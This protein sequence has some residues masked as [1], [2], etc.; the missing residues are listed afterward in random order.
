M[1]A[2]GEMVSAHRCGFGRVGQGLEI[3]VDQRRV[4][5]PVLSG[6][7]GEHNLG[8]GTPPLHGVEQGALQSGYRVRLRGIGEGKHL[9]DDVA[10]V[11]GGL[12]EAQ[13]E[14]AA[15]GPGHMGDDSVQSRPFLL[16][17]V[18]ANVDVLTEEAAAL[19]TPH[20]VGVVDCPCTRI[21]PSPVKWVR[22]VF[23]ERDHITHGS[24]PQTHDA[25]AGSRVDQLVDFSRLEPGRHIDVIVLRLQV[26]VLHSHE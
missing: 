25:A 22:G 21:A 10:D 16:I 4:A 17:L 20:G 12:P 7:V 6:G 19:G 5:A 26:R 3:R 18:D 24:E 11:F 2:A 13:I 15:H 8:H 23:Q 9:R 1:L 14:L